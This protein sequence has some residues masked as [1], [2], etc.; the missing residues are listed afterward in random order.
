[1]EEIYAQTGTPQS[2][3]NPPERRQ[4]R[5]LRMSLP[6]E[7]RRAGHPSTQLH[8]SVVRD[9]S[10]GG[11]FFETMLDD[12]RE[13]DLLDIELTI[14]PGQGHFPYQGR[15]S[16]TASVVRTEKLAGQIA[17]PRIGI[18]AAFRKGFKLA[19]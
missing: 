18:G 12:L 19:F 15:V 11:I 7:Y 3:P 8:R 14:P 10:T 13:G 9:V 2:V 4:H 5:R 1:M 16:S 6:L 17:S